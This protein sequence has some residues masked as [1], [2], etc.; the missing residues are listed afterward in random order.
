V[1]RQRE[2]QLQILVEGGLVFLDDHQII[3]H[4]ASGS[5][6]RSRARYEAHPA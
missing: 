1:W 4:F 5:A 2:E 3:G 6:W